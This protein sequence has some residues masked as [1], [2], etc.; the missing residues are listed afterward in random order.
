MRRGTKLTSREVLD[1]LLQSGRLTA[2]ELSAFKGWYDKLTS[3]AVAE[4]PPRTRLWV[5]AIYQDRGVGARR[6]EARKLARAKA[7][8]K[9]EATSVTAMPLPKKP[10]GK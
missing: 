10:P 8:A 9:K 1:R 2:Y 7:Q 5:D 6:A 3:G 4:L